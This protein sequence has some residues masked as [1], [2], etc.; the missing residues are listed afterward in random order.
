M[1]GHTDNT[2]E[3]AVLSLQ[4]LAILKLFQNKKYFFTRPRGLLVIPIRNPE[5]AGC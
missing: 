2:W 3:L 4:L 1:Q 5:V